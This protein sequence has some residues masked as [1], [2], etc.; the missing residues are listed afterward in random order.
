[1]NDT[2]LRTQERHG[3]WNGDPAATRRKHHRWRGGQFLRER[4]L[5]TAKHR[6]PSF[7][8]DPSD[9][10]AFA[11]LDFRVEVQERARQALRHRATDG[12]LAGTRQPDEH[13]VPIDLKASA[14]GHPTR[15]SNRAR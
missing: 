7:G 10:Q 8:E 3:T 14:L 13:Q 1:M 6:F 2:P 9:G 11:S 5:Q 15:S 4:V 12:G